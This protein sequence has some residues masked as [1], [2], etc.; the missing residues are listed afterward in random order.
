LEKGWYVV[1]GIVVVLVEVGSNLVGPILAVSEVR[2]LRAVFVKFSL[3]YLVINVSRPNLAVV[4][5]PP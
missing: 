1:V 2:R 5:K 3:W 4:V